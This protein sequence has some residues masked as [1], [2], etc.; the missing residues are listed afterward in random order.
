MDD[1]DDFDLD[2][3]AC[4][5]ALEDAEKAYLEQSNGPPRTLV[6]TST[7]SSSGFGSF[8][9]PLQSSLTSHAITQDQVKQPPLQRNAFNV[10]MASS[11]SDRKPSHDPY[12]PIR[13]DASEGLP[14]DTDCCHQVDPTTTDSWIYPINVPIRQYQFDIVGTCLI[15]NTLVALPTGLGKTFIAAVTMYN[16]YR[17]FPK[18]KVIFM[19]PTKPLV[20]Q[21]IEACFKITGIDPKET[22]ELTGSIAKTNRTTDWESKRV[23]FLTPQVI[24]NDLSS[25]V[26]DATSISLLVFDEVK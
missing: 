26:C 24:F 21:Q 20:A 16:Y 1:L 25:G 2:D 6:P 17:W 4:L 7:A 15:K 5:Q 9:P 22:A 14:Y 19:A 10:L 23:F 11:K 18:S 12:T 8:R 3:E 13:L